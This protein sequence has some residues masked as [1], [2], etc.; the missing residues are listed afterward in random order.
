MQEYKPT[1]CQVKRSDADFF[2]LKFFFYNANVFKQN[3][4]KTQKKDTIMMMIKKELPSV[5][6]QENWRVTYKP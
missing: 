1:Y 4:D 5:L 2:Y 6:A 3:K